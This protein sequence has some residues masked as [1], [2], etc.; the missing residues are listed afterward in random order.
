MKKI[1]S[2]LLALMLVAACSLTVFATVDK[3]YI[4]DKANIISDSE[5][6][7]LAK[8][9]KKL[10]KKYDLDIVI[11]TVETLDGADEV[12]YADDFYDS[13]ATGEDGALLLV[14]VDDDI[15][16]LSTCG[17]CIDRVTSAELGDRIS[18]YLDKGEYVKAFEGF[19]DLVEDEYSF[20]FFISLL[21]SV[22]IGLVAALIVTGI[23]K[24]KLKS[25]HKQ[26]AA[27][28]YVKAGS[29]KVTQSRDFFLYRNVVRRHVPKSSS[30]GGGG[31]THTSSSGRTHGGGRV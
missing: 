17:S 26:S 4:F 27:A 10:N 20:N 13:L 6:A 14:S 3:T 21:I 22:G 29:L 18:D 19:V 8:S 15:R 1:I 23:M 9:L 5:E 28:Q 25:V 11:L 16:Y 2:V 31:G 30:S 7:A 12:A 24:G